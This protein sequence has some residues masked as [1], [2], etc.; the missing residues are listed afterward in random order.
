M[1]SLPL[2]RL[3]LPA[4][5]LMLAACGGDGGGNDTPPL[6][7]DRLPLLALRQVAS[8]LGNPVFLS[9]PAGDT[10]LFIVEQAG[11]I[12]IV[13]AGAQLPTPFLDLSGKISAGGERGLLSL[14]FDP[15]YASN[16]YFYVYFTDVNGDIA[17]ERFSVAATNPDQAEPASALRI[18]SIPHP[19]YSNHN[20]GLLAFGADAYLYIGT[21]D[22]GGGGDP[23]GNA[24]NLGK[25]LGKLLRL[26]VRGATA[27][28]PYVIPA[29]NPFIGQ[30]GLRPEIWAYGLRNPWRYTFDGGNLYIADVGQAQREEINVVA[31]NQAGL[32]FGWNIMEG[33]RCYQNASCSATGLTPPIIDYDHTQGCSITGGYVYRGSAIPELQGR[34]FY[35]DYC[36][37]W[38]KSISYENAQASEPVSWPVA[39]VGPILSFGVD[40]QRELYLLSSEGGKVYRIERQ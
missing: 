23:D 24:Q 12:R 39:S 2:P 13:K 34:Y 26:D 10:R 15:Q 5:A 4:L 20:G 28:Q 11:R 40:G 14:A 37:G 6:A 25:L 31:S 32:N 3:M 8:G 27:A 9:A 18:L 29:G 1:N 19:V 16:G 17:I 21:G 30:G 7:S 36:A 22:G 38:L 33:K 35:S